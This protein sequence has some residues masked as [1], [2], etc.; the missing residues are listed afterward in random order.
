M[1]SF[2]SQLAAEA[3]EDWDLTPAKPFGLSAGPNKDVDIDD[4]LDGFDFTGKPVTKPEAFAPNSALDSSFDSSKLTVE[5]KPIGT[6]SL[7]ETQSSTSTSNTLSSRPA[8]QNGSTQ[9]R[10]NILDSLLTFDGGTD[11][12]GGDS[13]D[14]TLKRKAND[15]VAAAVDINLDNSFDIKPSRRSVRFS[16]NLND[17]LRE[18][19]TGNEALNSKATRSNNSAEEDGD[20]MVAHISSSSSSSSS[21]PQTAPAGKRRGRGS[22]SGWGDLGEEFDWPPKGSA[23]SD[24]EFKR[25]QQSATNTLVDRKNA[26]E[27]NKNKPEARS[28]IANSNSGDVG[29]DS[30]ADASE[31]NHMVKQLQTEVEGLRGLL[32]LTGE[33][34]RE[35][36][37]LLKQSHALKEELQFSVSQCKDRITQLEKYNETTRVDLTSAITATKEDALK[38]IETLRNEHALELEVIAERHAKALTN[39]REA[40]ANEARV[41]SDMQ[42]T[43]EALRTLLSQLLTATNEIKQAEI[44][45]QTAVTQR[46]AKLDRREETLKLAEERL[47]ER[48]RESEKAHQILT[49]AVAKLE[50][51]LREQGK[52]LETDRWMLRQEQARLTKLQV[53]LEEDRRALIEQAGKERIELQ[54]LIASFFAEHRETQAR[55]AA[56][57]NAT[58]EQQ[59]KL[60]SD[61]IN[62]RKQQEEEEKKL[63]TMKKELERAKETFQVERHALDERVHQ[64]HLTEVKLTE[65]QRHLD[66][67]RNNLQ[68]KETS[69]NERAA[70]L[71]RRQED[72]TSHAATLSGTQA[73]VAE[74]DA[75]CRRL[76]EEQEREQTVLQARREE[77]DD[78]EKRLFR[79]QEELAKREDDYA[80]KLKV[81]RKLVCCRC[82]QAVKRIP[83][84][85]RSSGSKYN[86][87][88]LNGE[89]RCSEAWSPDHIPRVAL[90]TNPEAVKLIEDI[91]NQHTRAR[92]LEQLRKELAKDN[93]FLED[94]RIYLSGLRHA[95]YT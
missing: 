51:Q 76:L 1:D 6:S 66:I 32:K 44:H 19:S 82:K 16:E 94:E 42:P 70:E 17:N 13:D 65:T 10:R 89:A 26:T 62:W 67:I 56:E 88:D 47:C 2:Y 73:A 3:N 48:E 41:L 23:T 34:H 61:Q 86:Q 12:T 83:H 93:E 31:S 24:S 87:P 7:N 36:I 38:T 79:E 52:S 5:A 43:V 95:S 60:R 74:I 91:S 4:L 85:D 90:D 8:P 59:Q 11:T 37:K 22:S 84:N 68:G 15:G 39:L 27:V 64:L 57:R 50:M 53:T 72:L 58:A 29:F 46:L 78:Q 33:Y 20:T 21:R 63:A 25:N 40:D 18:F 55:L 75:K 28:V 9:S 80:K 49:E 77:L 81:E 35:E 14:L 69:L 30:V 45:H 71:D 54:H 92:M